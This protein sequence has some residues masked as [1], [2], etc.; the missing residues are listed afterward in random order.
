MI[1]R[2]M[3]RGLGG[4]TALMPRPTIHMSSNAREDGCGS[5]LNLHLVQTT[6]LLQIIR[7]PHDAYIAAP[8][9][10]GGSSGAGRLYVGT[11]RSRCACAAGHGEK[12]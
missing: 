4:I 10:A 11:D 7:L 6:N 8:I 3:L 12:L 9:R 1:L 5:H 2:K